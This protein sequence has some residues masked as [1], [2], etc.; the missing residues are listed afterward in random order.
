M[1]RPIPAGKMRGPTSVANANGTGE[2]FLDGVRTIADVTRRTARLYGSLP[3]ILCRGRS[4]SHSELDRLSGALAAEILS[5]G[6]QPGEHVLV[7]MDNAAEQVVAYYAA[8]KAGTALTVVNTKHRPPE[9]AHQIANF[10]PALAIASP[11]QL[12][13]L[14]EAIGIAGK[15]PRVVLVI[16]TGDEAAP[17]LA[18][19][20]DDAACHE[21]IARLEQLR[22]SDP[23]LKVSPH[24]HHIVWYTSG[25]TG[26]PKGAVHTHTSTVAAMR[27]WSGI[28][29]LG[30]EDRSIAG[31][32]FHVGAQATVFAVI[33]N[34]GSVVMRDQ[35]F[36]IES[37]LQDIERFK[38]TNFPGLPLVF[39]LLQ[40]RPDTLVG[41][42]I[43]SVRRVIY[44]AAHSDPAIILAS[45][46]AFGPTVKWYH[47]YGQSEL[48]TGGT[49]LLEEEHATR[50]GSIGRPIACVDEISVRDAEGRALPSGTD[51]ELWVRGPTTMVGYLNDP[52][53]TA[54]TLV[55]GWIRT[56]DIAVIDA[57]GYVWL[58]DRRRDMIIRGGENVYPAEVENA[59]HTHPGVSEVA[60]V[61]APDKVM[62]ESPVAFVVRAEGSNATEADVLTHLKGRLARYK[63]PVAVVFVDE[64]PR[65]VLGKVLKYEL[66]ERAQ[67]FAR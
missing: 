13:C 43:S 62:G 18:E 40:L 22:G 38:V 29:S 4:F 66:R 3:A 1:A 64:L 20:A 32:L 12:R 37:T 54:E 25:T 21:V 27:A 26:V 56:G 65:S 10:S 55:D 8:A 67:Q 34:G 11:H 2:V 30:T 58:R 17:P 42:D 44:G 9:I 53:S 47:S 59:I 24:D 60:V 35:A 36:S 28:W 16:P 48:N 31:N 15:P 63:L 57:D 61:G 46:E 14:R 45:R 41:H 33:A 50:L 5:H 23:L 19:P 6:V 39:A 7:M 52:L 49:C 51:G